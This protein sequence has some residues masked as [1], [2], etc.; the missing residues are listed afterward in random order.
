M[1]STASKTAALRALDRWRIATGVVLLVLAILAVATF[2]DYGISHD[3]FVQHSYGKLLWKFYL[4]GFADR[5]AFSYIDLFRYGGLFD[6]AATAL[7]VGLPL[8]EYDTRHLLSALSGIVGIA[9]AGRLATLLGGTRAGFLAVALLALT[10]SYYGAMFNNTKDIP[11]AA[12]M[13]WTLYYAV[14]LIPELP[15]PG[16]GLV[17]KFGAVFGL[18]IG[19]R[20]GV[21][22]MPVYL[23]AGV[24]IWAWDRARE[25][26][27]GPA[28]A[29]RDVGRAALRLLPA[30]ALAYAIM[31]VTWPW[32]VEAP[33]NPLR[34]LAFFS[35]HPIRLNTQMFG[36]RIVSDT[37]PWY[38][39]P[40]YLLVKLPEVTLLLLA[41]GLLVLGRRMVRRRGA[42]RAQAAM[43]VLAALL[44]IVLFIVFRPT[45][46]NGLRHFF[47]VVPPLTAIAAVG[48]DRLLRELYRRRPT[49]AA[50]LAVMLLGAGLAEARIMLAL[51]PNQYVYYN[52]VAGGLAGAQDRFE[53]D[54][55]SN[56]I[57]EAA[58][59]L[60]D[61]VRAETGGIPPAQPYKV[62]LCS[63]KPTF[64]EH[65]PPGWFEPPPIW[66]L[67]DFFVAPTQ[68]GCAR[69][70]DGETIAV[71]ER[72][73]TPLAVIKDRRM[74]PKPD[75]PIA[76]RPPER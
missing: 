69:A 64:Y 37:T 74:L 70:L 48:A 59:L 75:V 72:L 8:P 18:A 1:E 68:M 45:V 7:A 67:G 62:A 56:S 36:I 53:M 76:G 65:V 33:L 19:I 32:G 22:M 16:I 54:Y 42:E 9:G 27:T 63:E 66:P 50:A 46:F 14:R 40:G 39:I 61:R 26:G 38:Y 57:R 12:G 2:R 13:I 31:A 17:L 47:F 28:V 6:L 73:G 25:E 34:A 23:L 41:P 4:S 20:V 10:G 11:F 58:L 49:L 5:S 55:W 60:Y 52:T 21:L 29:A 71:I 43:V 15:R 24:L 30:A 35:N 44:P 51:H 3:E